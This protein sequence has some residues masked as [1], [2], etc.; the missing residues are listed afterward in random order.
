[1]VYNYKYKLEWVGLKNADESDFYYRLKFY[2]KESIEKEY[3]I[4]TLTPSNQPFSLSYKSKS[5]YVFEPF[6]TSSAEINIFFD[7]NSV[8][9][10]EVFFDNTD[11]TTWKVV[12][13]LIK[14]VELF[15]NPDF[16][17]GWTETFLSGGV[18]TPDYTTGPLNEPSTRIKDATAY[19]AISLSENTSYTYSVWLKAN[20]G[21]PVATIFIGDSEYVINV[22]NTWTQY[23]F[24]V[25]KAEAVYNCGIEVTGDALVYYPNLYETILQGSAELWS[26]YVLNS[27]IQYD[28]QDQYFLRL[29]ATDFLGVLKEYKYSEY[30]EFSMFQ[31]QDFYEG[32]SIKDFIIRCLNLV[33]LEIDYKF[34]FNFTENNLAKNEVS[35]FINEYAAIDWKNNSPYD[36][37]KIIGNLLTSLGCILY[38]DNRDNT[39]TILAI[40]ELATTQNNLVPYRKYSYIDGSEITDGNY[41]I[42]TIIKQN[43]QTIFSDANQIVTLRPRLDEVQLMYPNKVKNLTIN[44]GF[45]QEDT[46]VFPNKPLFWTENVGTYNGEKGTSHPYDPYWMETVEKEDKLDPIDGSNYLGLSIDMKRFLGCFDPVLNTYTHLGDSYAFNLNFEFRITAPEPG[47]GFNVTFLSKRLESSAIYPIADYA[48][49]DSSGLWAAQTAADTLGSN[50]T[51]IEVYADNNMWKRFQV[52]SKYTQSS[53]GNTHSST[54]WF[55]ELDELQLRIRPMRLKSLLSPS[56]L[57]VDN[58]QLNIIPTRN[59]ALE[60][61][62]YKAIQNTDLNSPKPGYQK[63]IKVVESMFHTG[64][65]NGLSAVYYEDVIFTKETYDFVNYIQTSNKWRKPFM[66]VIEG[67]T[68]NYNYLNSL[69]A[70]SVLSFY[71]SPGRTYNG[72]VYAEQTPVQGYTPFAFPVYTEINGVFNRTITNNIANQFGADVIADG[73]T[74]ES[75]NCLLGNLNQIIN[76]SSNFFM[77]E[78]TFDYFN[79]K[80]NAKLEEDLTNNIEYFTLGLAPYQFSQSTLFGQPGSSTSNSQTEVIPPS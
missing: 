71:R 10:P 8:I 56:H 39:W 9:Q 2:K 18:I 28:W 49:F 78:A 74:F 77:S 51:R 27:D 48:S 72:N 61:L 79:N 3:E 13:E 34:A 40:N 80:T 58:I 26:G 21:S 42:K 23:D 52:L 55:W 65:S 20:E 15:T 5:D 44:Y 16:T 24:S 29:T 38:L 7:E 35:M 30:E 22:T 59:L 36:L 64:D 4:I 14:P 19:Q 46:S 32:I 66:Q 11:N 12:L 70:S 75:F 68:P 1:M 37:Q 76:I 41:N 54:N 17:S 60:K 31:S 73:G 57:N 50:P 45:F 67:E 47:D 6:R 53:G 62:G 33:G 63:N 25:T 69:T 43:T